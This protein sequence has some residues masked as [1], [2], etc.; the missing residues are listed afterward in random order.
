MARIVEL[1]QAHTHR[2][3]GTETN[4]HRSV[5]QLFT[6]GGMLVAEYDPH[7]SEAFENVPGPLDALRS[8][9]NGRVED[10]PR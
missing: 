9:W 4:P 7:V 2:G 5:S 10:D 6:K 8:W 3:N 1:I